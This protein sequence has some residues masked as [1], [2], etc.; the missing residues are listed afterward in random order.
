[1]TPTSVFT[2]TWGTS[3]SSAG[4]GATSPTGFSVKLFYL[5]VVFLDILATHKMYSDVC[6]G[7]ESF[8]PFSEY[9]KREQKYTF[10]FVSHAFT[11]ALLK[12]QLLPCC[13]TQLGN[14]Y[15]IR[16]DK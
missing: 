16:K 3:F 12:N 7:T 5:F 11:I 2:I 10:P 1:M 13:Q 8:S 4:S 14:L 6:G 9:G 15:Q